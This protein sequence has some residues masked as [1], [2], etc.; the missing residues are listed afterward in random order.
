MVTLF[1]FAI[2]VNANALFDGTEGYLGEF[3][4]DKKGY[5]WD[6]DPEDMQ[7][8]GFF[9]DWFWQPTEANMRNAANEYLSDMGFNNNDVIWVYNKVEF[10]DDGEVSGREG[11]PEYFYADFTTFKDEDEN[12]EPIAGTWWT[13]PDTYLVQFYSVMSAQ[14]EEETEGAA[15]YYVDPA[16]SSGYWSTA[17]FGTNPDGQFYGVS[18]LAA[19]AKES[20][21]VPEPGLLLLLGS[22]L[23]GLAAYG[24]RKI[25]G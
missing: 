2:T 15:L 16:A 7:W 20:V 11:T 24:R 18:H 21:P 10:F 23:I 9:V 5:Y 3:D 19:L 13:D 4:D 12:G 17:H 14:A 8:S 22:G 6:G 1:F 25:N